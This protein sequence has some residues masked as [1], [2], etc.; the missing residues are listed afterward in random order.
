MSQISKTIGSGTESRL[1]QVLESYL[2]ACQAG[3]APDQ[4]ELL[5]RHPELAEDLKDCLA[6]L[7]FIGQGC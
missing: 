4:H 7:E 3:T 1:V 6:S 5:A 2:A